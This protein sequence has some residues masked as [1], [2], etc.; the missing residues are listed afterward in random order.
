MLQEVSKE[1][2]ISNLGKLARSIECRFSCG[3]TI[4][5]LAAVDLLYKKPSGDWSCIKLPS[6][7]NDVNAKELLAS[8]STASFGLGSETVTDE[9]YRDAL[10]LEPDYFFTNFEV[11]NTRILDLI[12]RIMSIKMSI[13]AELYKL[14]IYSM[15]GHFKSHV[16][17]PRSE[18]MFG[19]LVV[20]LPSQFTGGVLVTRHQ[21]REVTF[22]WSSSA[23]CHWAA[24]FSDVEHEVLPVT[25]GYRITLTYNLYHLA[26]LQ[27]RRDITWDKLLEQA[28]L[29]SWE[30]ENIS[31]RGG[32]E[33]YG[34][35]SQFSG[36][37]AQSKL[38]ST[39]RELEL[40]V[41]RSSMV[42]THWCGRAWS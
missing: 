8:C 38:K 11:A 20:C 4:R 23:F 6:E 9:T 27:G 25:G 14:N 16:D 1:T 33:R 42:L 35:P 40:I 36:Y 5:E 26:P 28:G 32:L 31:A 2:V 21:G 41:M 7:I 12:T 24:F 15:G 13:R 37:N 19:S 34:Q 18:D 10:K 17:T 29:D 39:L 22:E 3:G 30:R